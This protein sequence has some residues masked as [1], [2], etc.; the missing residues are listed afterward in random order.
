MN[1]KTSAKKRLLAGVV[2]LLFLLLGLYLFSKFSDEYNNPDRIKS[3]FTK[4]L[5][6]KNKTAENG[7]YDL[8]YLTET[9]TDKVLDSLFSAEVFRLH[10]G[11]G[12]AYFI[13]QN[14]KLIFWSD[15]NIPVP[16]FYQYNYFLNSTLNPGNG[17][18][19][20]IVKKQGNKKFVALIKIKDEYPVSNRYLTNYFLPEY[21]IPKDA[22]VTNVES[23]DVL[24][25][26]EEGNTLMAVS[27]S[28]LRNPESE[29]ILTIFLTLII[30]LL[31]WLLYYITRII[32][33]RKWAFSFLMLTGSITGLFL[34]IDF[35][36]FLNYFGNLPI[37]APGLYAG[38]YFDSLGNLI[39]FSFGFCMC[40]PD[41]ITH[42][43][44]C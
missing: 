31:F 41:F 23:G 27:L 34:F 15:R 3:Q 35:P 36:P 13:Y 29:I 26:D 24:L 33:N 1:R 8:I 30:S 12:I 39:I 38:K 40:R 5:S 18:Y 4:E 19:K 22:K 32:P 6:K 42:F 28:N 10:H 44:G 16:S 25:Q 37:F 17:Y 7:I 9:G 43:R 20:P 14:D 11:H 2:L 21:G